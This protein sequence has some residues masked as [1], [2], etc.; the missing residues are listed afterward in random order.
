[1]AH[2]GEFLRKY[3]REHK[4]TDQQIADH[5]SIT[6]S[7]VE[8]IFHQEDIYVSRLILLSEL[9]KTDFFNYYYNQQPLKGIRNSNIKKLEDDII[10]LKKTVDRLTE[11]AKNL[12]HMNEVQQKVISSL[13]SKKK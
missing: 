11:H 8:K 6:K 4:I 2:I 10:G 5:L 3:F 9:A 1:M 7:A 12:E 13:K